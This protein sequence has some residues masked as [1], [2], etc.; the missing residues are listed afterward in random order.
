[1]L[2]LLVSLLLFQRPTRIVAVLPIG[3]V[4]QVEEA[5]RQVE[6]K[7]KVQRLRLIRSVIFV[8][9]GL[10]VS[11]CLSLGS[12]HS[13]LPAT[14]FTQEK[15][16]LCAINEV[17]ECVAVTG[18]SPVSLEDANLAGIM[19]IDMEKKQLRTAPLGGEHRAEDIESVEVNDKAI[20]LNG[21][22]KR[23]TNRT[24]S[25]VISLESGNVNAGVSTLDSSL[26]L[27]GKCSAQP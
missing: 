24:W 19:L 9:D 22:G 3:P 6:G 26:S 12:G 15:S 25:A 8:N 10:E 4:F 2:H 21:T 14:G 16:Y 13:S 20:L 11:G 23:E 18:C 1:V 7:P 5:E 17:Y 27:L